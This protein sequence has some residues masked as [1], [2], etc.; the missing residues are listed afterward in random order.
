M[1]RGMTVM[2][3][4]V[5]IGLLSTVLFV[6]FAIYATCLRSWRAVDA[7]SQASRGLSVALQHLRADLEFAHFESL[8]VDG[9]AVALLHPLPA[10]GQARLD[11][12][13]VPTWTE[14]VI[15]YHDAST[16]ELRRISL[17]F[18]GGQPVDVTAH[19]GPLAGLLSG[20]ETVA[21]GVTEFLPSV[22]TTGHL[23]VEL[24]ATGQTRAGEP[25]V[26]IVRQAL[27]P[28]LN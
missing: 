5:T 7:R 14:Y 1:K 11:S 25:A 13:R 12:E 21:S 8:Q 18:P 28:V 23:R 17:G 20:G 26:S 24:K 16:R 27:I 9:A 19:H 15:Y 22:E 6:V 4:V 10:A 3:L 2:E